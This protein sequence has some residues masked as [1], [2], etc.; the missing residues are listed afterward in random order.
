MRASRIRVY[1]ILGTKEAW[2]RKKSDQPSEPAAVSQGNE[3]SA[4][5]TPL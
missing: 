4:G 2:K 5:T 1:N 3:L